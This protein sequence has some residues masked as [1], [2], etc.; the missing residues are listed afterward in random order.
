MCFFSFLFM[1]C[2]I[3][4][5]CVI[6]LFVIVSEPNK[7]F[8]TAKI[9]NS[10]YA[11]HVPNTHI[12]QSLLRIKL[13]FSL[14]ISTQR[15][16]KGASLITL[17]ISHRMQNIST[18]AFQSYRIYATCQTFKTWGKNEPRQRFKRSQILQEN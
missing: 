5:V 7:N 10:K 18:Q 2:K 6:E 4:S 8:E 16:H 1:Y 11:T 13:H 17:I 9:S 3:L 15:F 12:S 14:R